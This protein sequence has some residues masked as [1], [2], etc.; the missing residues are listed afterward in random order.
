VLLSVQMAEQ[1][2]GENDRGKGGGREKKERSDDAAADAVAAA[3]LPSAVRNPCVWTPLRPRPG[4]VAPL[5]HA[6]RKYV[7]HK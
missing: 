5:A 1:K 3:R 7:G 4:E 2:R 6:S